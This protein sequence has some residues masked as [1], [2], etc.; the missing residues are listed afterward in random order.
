MRRAAAVIFDFDGVIV[1]SEN[2]Q[3]RAYSAILA[4]LGIEVTR[5]EYGREWIAAGLG[6]EYAVAKYGL[7]VAAQELRA[8]KGPVYHELLRHEAQLM[9]G[10]ASVLAALAH[11]YPLA[12]ATNSGLADTA[13]VLDH[14]ALRE[15]FKAVITR[16]NYS[17]RKPAPDA[18]LT[19]AAALDRSPAQCVVV[20]DAHKGVVAA[21]RAGC[22]CVA[23]PHEFTRDNDFRLAAAV[24]E[25][26]EDLTPALIDSLVGGP[27]A[28]AQARI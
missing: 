8:R 15:H 28:A 14:F 19:A 5:E 12:L 26:L 16:E 1:D 23:V 11:I 17:E 2:L 4:E 22:P 27:V 20:E 7:T 18:F 13:F 21:Y 25:S 6:P 24:V 9:P 3:Y 10:V